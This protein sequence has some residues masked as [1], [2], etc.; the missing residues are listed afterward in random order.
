MS[1]DQEESIYWRWLL[2]N[3]LL[4][5]FLFTAAITVTITVLF[6][7][8]NVKNVDSRVELVYF[9]FPQS[10]LSDYGSDNLPWHTSRVFL[11]RAQSLSHFGKKG[12]ICSEE[13]S[14]V[15][16]NIV[17]EAEAEIKPS[18]IHKHELAGT[19]A[20]KDLPRLQT[21]SSS[22][23]ICQG[24]MLHSESCACPGEESVFMWII[25]ALSN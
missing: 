11:K 3:A 10:L 16:S 12:L 25:L 14:H 15:N 18:V 23:G 6:Q 21:G 7:S 19:D 2:G 20:E 17:E 9:L 13:W 4:S 1:S 22:S 5:R 8:R 24:W